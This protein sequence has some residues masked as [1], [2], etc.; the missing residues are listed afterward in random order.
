MAVVS[1]EG[2]KPDP[3]EVAKLRDCDVPRSKTSFLGVS[4]YYWDYIPWHAKLVAPFMQS[5]A[6]K[7]PCWGGGCLEQEKAFNNI[8]ITLIEATAL[9]KPDSG[10]FVLDTDAGGVAISVLLHQW[11]GLHERRTLRPIIFGSRQLTTTQAKYGAPKLEMDAAYHFILKYRSYRCHRKFPL[12]VDKQALSC[13]KTYSTDQA[14]IGQWIM[15]LEKYHFNIEHRPRTQHRN[16]DGL[17]KRP[18]NYKKREALLGLQPAVVD[19][20]YF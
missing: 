4:N 18:N 20:C 2:I 8:K 16:A 3:K 6:S 12:V 9:A 11:Q 1:A 13:F 17:N 7:R 19:K 14:I 5:L 10:E 15:A